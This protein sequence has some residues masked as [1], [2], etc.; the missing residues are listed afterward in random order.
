MK[1]LALF[2]TLAGGAFVATPALA[3]EQLSDE[4]MDQHRAGFITPTG[5]E[6]GL[7][8]SVRTYVDGQL[9]LETRLT[10]TEAGVTRELVSGQPTPDPAAAAARFGLDLS[11]DW[12]GLVIE[13]TDGVTAVLTD[14]SDQRVANVL[15]NTASDQDI[16]LETELTLNMPQLDDFQAQMLMDQT[17]QSLHDSIGSALSG[18]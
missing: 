7:G 10:W 4:Q 15:V 9:A 1:N 5:L 11:G 2:L 3:R 6:V 18:F 14:I 12:N 16:R 13:R 8:A 17:T